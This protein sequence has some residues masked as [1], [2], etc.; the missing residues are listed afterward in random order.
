MDTYRESI[1]TSG[2]LVTWRQCDNS[3]EITVN[4]N[5]FEFCFETHE[6]EAH[7]ILLRKAEAKLTNIFGESRAKTIITDFVNKYQD[8]NPED[9][10]VY[11]SLRKSASELYFCQ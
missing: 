3:K 1:E 8:Y 6:E 5:G 11:A 7:E 2:V 10:G 9:F 4:G